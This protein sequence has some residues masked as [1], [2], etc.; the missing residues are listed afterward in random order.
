MAMPEAEVVRSLDMDVEQDERFVVD[1]V[2]KLDWCIRQISKI[3]KEELPYIECAQRQIARLQEFI[4]KAEERIE[5]RTAY[6]KA[7]MRPFVEQ[8]LADSR[9]KTINAPSGSVSLRKQEPEFEKDDDKLVAWLEE[10]GKRKFV[11]VKKQ[12]DWTEFKKQLVDVMEDGTVVTVDGE[13]LPVEAIR[14]TK[15]PDK[16]YVKPV[17]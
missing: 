14:A 1:S 16:L 12:T 15:R 4:R 17:V 5:E 6:F 9:R 8:T 13:L 10:N 11:R 3:E 2:D 7:L